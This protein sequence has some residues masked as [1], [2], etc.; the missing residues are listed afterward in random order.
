MIDQDSLI[1]VIIDVAPQEYQSV[2]TDM[3]LRLQNSVT[4]EDLKAR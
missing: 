2:L 4:L 1:A 3:Q